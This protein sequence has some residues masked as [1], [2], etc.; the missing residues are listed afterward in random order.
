VSEQ[1][2]KGVTWSFGPASSD[3]SETYRQ[4]ENAEALRR[5]GELD[6]AR[7]LCEPLV[8][9]YP[10]YFGALHTLGLVFADK[11]QYPQALGCLVRAVMLNPRSWQALTA[12]STVYLELG[13]SE[14]AAQALE[15][16]RLLNPRDASIFG[17]LGEIYQAEREYELAHDAYHSALDLDPSLDLVEIGLGNCCRQLGRYAEAAKI[18]EGLIKRGNRS[19]AVLAALVGLPMSSVSFDVLSE[20]NKITADKNANKAEFENSVAVIKAAA[21]DRVGRSQEAWRSIVP[22]NRSIFLARQQDARDVGETQHKSLARLKTRTIKPA[23]GAGKTISLF[24]LGPSRSGKTT[25]ETLIATL[26]GVKRGYENPIVENAI[27]RTF[28][29]AGLLTDRAFEMLPLRLDSLCREIYMEDLSRRAGAAKVFTN[30]HPARIH[31]AARVAAAFPG[32]RF[33]FVKRNLDD[34]M[35]RIFM[36]AY[37]V[38]NSYSYDL[39]AT[40]EHLLWYH[41][42]IDTLA[43]KLPEISRVIQYE[44]IIA[45]PA[46]ALR[47]GADLCGLTVKDGP[48]P[49]LGDDRNCAEPYRALITAAPES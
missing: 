7:A 13:A 1:R 48:I 9:R 38:G 14:M 3:S 10:D 35:L 29:S 16:A 11:G 8:A 5:Q 24:I 28:Q 22:A 2:F 31:D 23:S 18:F 41:Q 19:L 39:K 32:A 47:T 26:D 37:A 25:M 30:T 33:I 27:R 44:D 45:N 46:S 42:M 34:N 40:R 20:L 17:T 43:E 49:E 6:R 4:L 21:L 15:Q 12:L 36:R